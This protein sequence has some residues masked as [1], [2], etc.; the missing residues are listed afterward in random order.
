MGSTSLRSTRSGCTLAHDDR[1]R[2]N[3]RDNKYLRSSVGRHEEG[4]RCLETPEWTRT[5]RLP[6]HSVVGSVTAVGTAANDGKVR[7]HQHGFAAACG[8]PLDH[9]SS[10]RAVHADQSIKTA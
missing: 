3:A 7:N 5:K 9:Q 8:R 4:A 6:R 2:V 10:N 1:G